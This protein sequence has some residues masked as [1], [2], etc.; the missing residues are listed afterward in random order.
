[1]PT[2]TRSTRRFRE[3]QESSFPLIGRLVYDAQ[4]T[5]CTHCDGEFVELMELYD[6]A[7]STAEYRR[8]AETLMAAELYVAAKCAE[9][10]GAVTVYES[11]KVPGGHLF[12][13]L[14]LP[15]YDAHWRDICAALDMT[16][17]HSKKQV[18]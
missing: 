2:E 4:R 14:D 11:I 8:L 15:R 5:S 1:M 9:Y 6:A 13:I 7:T 16:F 12:S 18:A 17:I 10:V 3:R